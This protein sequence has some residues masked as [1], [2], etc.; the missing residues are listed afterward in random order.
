MQ[1]KTEK[2]TILFNQK[3]QK[4]LL[5]RLAQKQINGA[6]KTVCI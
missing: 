4:Q 6:G 5:T 1:N 2:V 3:I